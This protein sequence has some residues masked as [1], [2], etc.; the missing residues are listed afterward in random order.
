VARGFGLLATNTISQ[1]D[2]REVGLDQL[3]D[4]GWEIYR[5][6]KSTPWPGS[7][8]LEIAKVWT[9]NQPWRGQHILESRPVPGITTSL[10]PK[11]RSSGKPF[12]LASNADQSFQGSIPLGG[13]FTLAPKEA[14]ALIAKDPGNDAILLPFLNGKDLSGSPTQTPSRWVINFFDWSEQRARRHHDA[15]RIVEEKVRPV[16]ASNP[17]G[18][19]RERWWQYAER[20]PRLYAAIDGFER[21]LVIAQTSPG[22]ST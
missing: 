12:R 7:A 9:I 3:R 10:E 11:S 20:A 5:A 19:R 15:F 21:V 4:A 2:T 8:T 13:G 18:P 1:G 6:V 22:T 16:R 17:R 14:H